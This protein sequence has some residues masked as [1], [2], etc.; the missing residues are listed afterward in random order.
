VQIVETVSAALTLMSIC[1]F[2]VYVVSLIHEP[3]GER[4]RTPVFGPLGEELA[5][6]ENPG[7]KETEDEQH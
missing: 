3:T 6:E 1:F 5:P 4:P 7:Y 2:A